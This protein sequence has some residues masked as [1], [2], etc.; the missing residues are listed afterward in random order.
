MLAFGLTTLIPN[1]KVYTITVFSARGLQGVA[2]A[3]NDTTILSI[4]G[5]LYKDHQDIAL[6]CILG[7]SGFAFT[8]APLI[9]SILY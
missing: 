3:C 6:A 5:L 1:V 7:I 9:G 2:A 4:V 8:F